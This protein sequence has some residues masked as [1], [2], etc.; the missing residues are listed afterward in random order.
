MLIKRLVKIIEENSLDIAKG[1]LAEIRESPTTQS[2]AQIPDDVLLDRV[3]I[4]Y[5]NFGS[6]IS[7]ETTKE[8]IG[9]YYTQLGSER[10]REGSLEGSWEVGEKI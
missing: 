3:R 5:E 10:F 8:K 2:F 6:W 1:W 4:I 9:R 7:E